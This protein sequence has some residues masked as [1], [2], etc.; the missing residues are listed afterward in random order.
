MCATL[1]T[2]GIGGAKTLSYCCGVVPFSGEADG[3]AEAVEGEI[4]EGEKDL[5]DV[6]EEVV[7]EDSARREGAG[8]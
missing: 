7:E 2:K 3:G 4:G 8:E 1:G 6:G 5:R